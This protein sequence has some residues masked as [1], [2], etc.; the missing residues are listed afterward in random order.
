MSAAS[1]LPASNLT[2]LD[3]QNEANCCGARFQAL[4]GGLPAYPFATPV[5]VSGSTCLA[6][7]ENSICNVFAI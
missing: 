3:L 6:A 2:K 1:L 5:L 4:L 7:S